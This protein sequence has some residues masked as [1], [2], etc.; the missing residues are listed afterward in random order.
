ME[1]V[2]QPSP[3]AE[4]H[5]LYE[6]SEP[7]R[8]ERTRTAAIGSILAHIAIV[9]ILMALPAYVP[10]A[11]EFVAHQI[12]TPLIEPPTPLTQKAPN[13][14]K[15]T[16]EFNANE[17]EPRPRIQIPQGAAS[18]SRPAPPR[19]AAPIPPMPAPKVA[20]QTPL[21]EPPKLEAKAPA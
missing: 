13:T 4:L 14:S 20:Q 19:P 10:P 6:W 21:P 11:R 18:T 3:D 16:K 5:L 2:V 9:A 7:G 15:V 8:G 12:I 1:T 17:V